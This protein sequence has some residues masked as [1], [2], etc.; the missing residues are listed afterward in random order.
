MIGVGRV[1]GNESGKHEPTCHPPIHVHSHT[2]SHRITA[3]F[4]VM[5]F[6]DGS[7]EKE[8]KDDASLTHFLGSL[9]IH[10]CH[11]VDRP[12]VLGGFT[13]SAIRKTR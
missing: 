1:V 6:L 4:D 10:P 12:T 9:S 11:E 13:P 3:I 8:G 2:Y 7:R 5:D